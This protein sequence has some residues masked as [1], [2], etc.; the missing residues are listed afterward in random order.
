[1]GVEGVEF[2][3]KMCADGKH[4]AAV[5]GAAC[6]ASCYYLAGVDG[7]NGR[8]DVAAREG[9]EGGAKVWGGCTPC[10]P[11]APVKVYV[12]LEGQP[13]PRFSRGADCQE[14]ALGRTFVT[15]GAPRIYNII[16]EGASQAHSVKLIPAGPGVVPL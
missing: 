11:V 15:V 16:S 1:M 3:G 13:V 5:G 12:H 10:A 8:C 9:A 14:D 4:G 7:L 6:D 2:P